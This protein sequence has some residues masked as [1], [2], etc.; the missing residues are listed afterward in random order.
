MT[1]IINI[2]NTDYELHSDGSLWRQNKTTSN[3]KLK[4]YFRNGTLFYQFGKIQRSAISLV[5][6]Y[7]T[8]P[9]YE[10]TD[11]VLVDNNLGI[12]PENIKYINFPKNIVF[13]YDNKRMRMIS[14]YTAI[15]EDGR[16]YNYKTNE[17][18]Y[19]SKTRGVP[20]KNKYML[21]KLGRYEPKIHRLV[22]EY[23]I[24]N[25]NNLPIVD[26]INENKLDNRVENLRWCTHKENS[27][28]Y[29]D[30]KKERRIK[31]I[32]DENEKLNKNISI[33][34]RKERELESKIKKLEYK[35]EQHLKTIIKLEIKEIII[36]D[37]NKRDSKYLE[38]ISACS[39][40]KI[41]GKEIKINDTKFNSISSSAK[42]IADNEPTK[43]VKTIRKEISRFANGERPSW[44]MYGK[45]KI[46]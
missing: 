28:F 16:I 43:N 30:V 1:K 44:I 42:Y 11:I 40:K 20:E 22:A 7:F 10:Y 14:K 4:G 45:Y 33:L 35:E 17:Y 19:G 27:N 12:S 21:A 25:P 37:R 18:T 15:T 46:S 23:F 36:K 41:V 24:P 39:N 38:A 13:K 5:S 2:N 32:K 6:E 8:N 31:I 34:K 26:H 3:R 29:H 9:P